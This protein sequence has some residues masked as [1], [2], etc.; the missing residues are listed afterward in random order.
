MSANA[1]VDDRIVV[2]FSDYMN[3]ENTTLLFPQGITGNG[4][5]Q[6]PVIDPV[7]VAKDDFGV[8]EDELPLFP[9]E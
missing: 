9:Q 7:V 8:S 2:T 3:G 4:G 1:R 6:C 5:A